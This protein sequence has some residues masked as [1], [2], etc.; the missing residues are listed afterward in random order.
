MVLASDILYAVVWLV[1]IAAA[2]DMVRRATQAYR[3][4]VDGERFDVLEQRLRDLNAGERLAKLEQGVVTLRANQNAPA[5]RK[6]G[7]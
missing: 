3:G 2:W 5:R 1:A 4:R 7:E 6:W